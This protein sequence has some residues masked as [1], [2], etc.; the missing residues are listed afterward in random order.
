[1]KKLKMVKIEVTLYSVSSYASRTMAATYHAESLRPSYGMSARATFSYALVDG[2]Q[3]KAGLEV[4]SA[5]K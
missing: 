1:V 2:V 4:E 5:N 3:L